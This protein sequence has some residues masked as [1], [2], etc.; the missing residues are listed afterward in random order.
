MLERSADIPKQTNQDFVST[1]LRFWF[2]WRRSPLLSLVEQDSLLTPSFNLPSFTAMHN[3]RT[4]TNDAALT[5]FPS[6]L[7]MSGA[8][9]TQRMRW[10]LATPRYCT[11][12]AQNH[13][14]GPQTTP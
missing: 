14:Q 4:A 3:A 2:H 8:L 13:S 7:R 9:L 6:A 1:Q 10:H 5:A 11:Y 12:I